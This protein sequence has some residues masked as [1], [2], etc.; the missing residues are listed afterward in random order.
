MNL[1]LETIVTWLCLHAPH[2]GGWPDGRLGEWLTWWARHSSLYVV[3]E[4]EGEEILAVGVAYPCD[5]EDLGRQW[6][7]PKPDGPCFYVE[8]LVAS[9]GGATGFFPLLDRQVTDWREKYLIGR[10]G[11]RL[12]W[13]EPEHLQR[14]IN[15][16]LCKSTHQLHGQWRPKDARR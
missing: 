2:F 10:R 9:E 15:R 13:I 5:W 7:V 3:L 6:N 16:N 12:K 4:S 11:T 8:C 1:S 14:W